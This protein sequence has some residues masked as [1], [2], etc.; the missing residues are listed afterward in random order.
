MK[1]S[2]WKNRFRTRRIRWNILLISKEILYEKIPQEYE[3]IPRFI[4]LDIIV[5]VIKQLEKEEE[6]LRGCGFL[7]FNL[8]DHTEEDGFRPWQMAD[9][10]RM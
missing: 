5:N 7:E 1:K 2:N 10:K 8:S 3:E 4:W 6:F 9:D